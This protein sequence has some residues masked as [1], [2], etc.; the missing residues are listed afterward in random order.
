MS[1]EGP[2][3]FKDKHVVIFGLGL[4]GGSAAKALKGQCRLLSGIDPNPAA[5]ESALRHGVVD[6]ADVI[7]GD[8]ALD[9]DFIILAVP[10]NNILSLLAELP[11]ICPGGAVVLDFGST[12]QH[13]CEAMRHLPDRFDPVGGHPMCGKETSGLEY[14]DPAMFHG[15]AFV[16]VPLE[17]TSP[18][19]LDGVEAFVGLLGAHP[20]QLDAVS[21]DRQV[22]ATSHVPYL[23]SNTLAFSTP[24]SAAPLAATGF[25]STT[26]LALT[27]PE[28]M[29]DVLQT[30]REAILDSL[31][32]YREHLT[33]VENLLSARDW[34]G[35]GSVLAAG[36]DHRVQIDL[37][38]KGKT[39]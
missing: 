31:K 28:M 29:M 26:R 36:A 3:F 21:H 20:I 16:L 32:Q 34:T 25:S 38:N 24:I 4:M 10:V 7:P 12:K 23:I 33:C 18:A 11:K 22:A 1:D 39:L 15:A 30:N 5:V 19:A 17:R 35:L 8:M 27:P 37:V 6:Q 2:G 14:A 13:I 9:A